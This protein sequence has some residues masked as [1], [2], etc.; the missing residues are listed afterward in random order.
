MWE[1]NLFFDNFCDCQFIWIY[2]WPINLR[3]N[4]LNLVRKLEK[5]KV[6]LCP[7]RLYVWCR[8]SWCWFVMNDL[9]EASLCAPL[10]SL[11]HCS[12]PYF[13]LNW[14]NHC[15]LHSTT[16]SRPLCSTLYLCFHTV[17]SFWHKRNIILITINNFTKNNLPKN[18]VYVFTCNLY[19][20]CI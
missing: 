16:K 19:Y 10:P 6:F 12:L 17:P 13:L 9:L 4:L 1:L 18:N 2:S 5:W 8:L 14:Q 20:F 15:C 11:F 7:T 3:E